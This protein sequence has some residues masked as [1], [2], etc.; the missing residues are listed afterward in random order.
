MPLLPD[1]KPHISLLCWTLSC[2]VRRSTAWT[3]CNLT[4]F[5]WVARGQQSV[6][7]DFTS[8][9]RVASAVYAPVLISQGSWMLLY[10]SLR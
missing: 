7:P 1:T 4:R 2:A 6:S 9:A 5:D 10:C 8:L 3:H